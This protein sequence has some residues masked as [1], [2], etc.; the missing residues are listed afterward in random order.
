[1][2]S[3][4][5]RFGLMF[6]LFAGIIGFVSW[7]EIIISF[8]EPVDIYEDLPKDF[9]DVKAVET[10]LYVLMDVFASEQTTTKN[11]SGH[12]TST[13]Y[14]YYYVLPVFTEEETYYAA[15]KVDSEKSKPYDKL[16]DLTW[17]YLNGEVEMLGSK[18][19]EFQGGFVKMEDDLYEYFEEWFEEEQFFES[20]AEMEKY[21]LPLVLEPI[22]YENV[23]ILTYVMVGLI[24]VGGLMVF[25]G[26]RKGKIKYKP[27]AHPMIA[28]NGVNYPSSNFESVNKL[29]TKGDKVKA[30]KELQKITGIEADESTFVI[31]RWEEY[32]G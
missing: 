26:L 27:S 16:T 29:V 12:I 20:D 24:V 4:L 7:E 9:N 15:V 2:K 21:L 6:L 13:D 19:I 25:F 30:A 31:D 22:V 32:W 23:R 14:D 8:S 17:S 18:T 11:R 3:V 1:M 5:V 10:E 28:I